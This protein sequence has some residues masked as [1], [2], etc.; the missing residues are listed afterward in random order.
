[1]RLEFSWASILVVKNCPCPNSPNSKC[2]VC[3]GNIL[4][5]G[6]TFV[7]VPQVDQHMKQAG[8]AASACHETCRSG[9]GSYFHSCPVAFAVQMLFPVHVVASAV[10]AIDLL[11]PSWCCKSLKYTRPVGCLTAMLL[12]SGSGKEKH[13][14][15]TKFGGLS[16]DWLGGKT[17]SCIFWVVPYG[18]EKAR[19]QNP[20]NILQKK[21]FMMCFYLRCFFPLPS[22]LARSTHTEKSQLDLCP[23]AL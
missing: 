16:R 17:F 21:L 10:V 4:L 1:M 11:C 13:I 12:L 20:K 9:R 19:K 2:C 22:G 7:D 6:G 15:I 18:G 8:W 14:N 5:A 3:Q 23:G